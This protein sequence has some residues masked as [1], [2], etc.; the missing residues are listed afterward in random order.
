M[1]LC[2]NHFALKVF[3]LFYFGMS[4]F[5]STN[6]NDDVKAIAHI[7]LGYYDLA[8]LEEGGFKSIGNCEA[9]VLLKGS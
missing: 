5:V 9:L 7:S 1:F 4:L 6:L 3:V 2:N 8:V